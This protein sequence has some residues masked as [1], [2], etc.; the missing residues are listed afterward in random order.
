[1]CFEIKGKKEIHKRCLSIEYKAGLSSGGSKRLS[2]IN[3][4]GTPID[5][6]H[7]EGRTRQDAIFSSKTEQ[8]KGKIQK[9]R[10]NF[11]RLDETK[12]KNGRGEHGNRKEEGKTRGK[13]TKSFR[14]KAK[15]K[16]SREEGKTDRYYLEDGKYEENEKFESWAEKLRRLW[17]K[18]GASQKSWQIFSFVKLPASSTGTEAC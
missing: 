6:K 9:L 14:N 2:Q 8:M 13:K 1:M 4:L 15:R 12:P 3:E 16:K 17:E 7:M 11:K 10:E 18:V 5:G